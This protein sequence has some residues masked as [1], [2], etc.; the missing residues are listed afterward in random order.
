MTEEAN[1]QQPVFPPEIFEII[2]NNLAARPW[3]IVLTAEQGAALRSC[4]L[5]CKMFLPLARAHLLYRLAQL[6]FDDQDLDHLNQG[7]SRHLPVNQF[8]DLWERKPFIKRYVQQLSLQLKN[9]TW[10]SIPEAEL[11]RNTNSLLSLPSVKSI[12]ISY[13]QAAGLV[14]KLSSSDQIGAMCIRLIDTYAAKKT[15]HTLIAKKMA[16]LPFQQLFA[17]G[18]LTTLS[19]DRCCMPPLTGPIIGIKSLTLRKM[20]LPVSTLSFFP[21]LEDLCIIRANIT[22]C[23]NPANFSPPSFR[24]K[25]LVLDQCAENVYT[26]L[27][28]FATSIS[29]FFQYFYDKAEKQSVKPFSH[30]TK[31][32]VVLAN[33]SQ[34]SVM[35]PILKDVAQTLR[36]FSFGGS[37]TGIEVYVLTDDS[38]QFIAQEEDV[39]EALALKIA[40]GTGAMAATC[41]EGLNVATQGGPNTAMTM[42]NDDSEYISQQPVFPLEIFEVI[43]DI[44]AARPSTIALTKEQ[45]TTLKA[46]ALVCKMFLNLARPHLYRFVEVTLETVTVRLPELRHLNDFVHLW[47]RKPVIKQYVQQLSFQLQNLNWPALPSEAE[48]ERYA[49]SLSSLPSVKIIAI[50]YRQCRRASNAAQIPADIAKLSTSDRVGALF[51]RL[52]E[53]CAA[54]KTL[55]TLSC[56]KM[57]QLPYQQLFASVTLTTLSLDR[58]GVPPLTEP[59]RGLKSLTLRKMPLPVS[60]LSFF[61]DLDYLG[62]FRADITKC[63]RAAS[64]P[65]P[66]FGLK[67][68]D[69]DRCT[70]FNESGSLIA[71]VSTFLQFYYD[72]AEEQGVK[73][74]SHLTTLA[75]IV[76]QDD[77]SEL[78]VFE[79]LLKDISGT[80]QSFTFG[81]FPP[82]QILTLDFIKHLHTETTTVSLRYQSMQWLDL[83]DDVN[84]S[85]V[86][87][88]PLITSCYPSFPLDRILERFMTQNTSSQSSDSD[89][90]DDHPLETGLKCWIQYFA[91]LPSSLMGFTDIDKVDVYMVVND[92]GHN[93][94]IKDEGDMSDTFAQR[95]AA[96]SGGMVATRLDGLNSAQ[97]SRAQIMFYLA[98]DE[99]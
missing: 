67:T 33:Y 99:N 23:D 36:W 51:M 10:P 71:S 61:P 5:T 98:C 80:L 76:I 60:T 81:A 93:V 53:A 50:S 97:G 72:K 73:P 74:F 88:V 49:H 13:S 8:V 82:P 11:D 37:I 83:S 3:T 21:D 7:A 17:S 27:D 48:F 24:L 19:L 84:I 41:V 39:T 44:L 85:F 46:C 43:I 6:Q 18:S 63:D 87:L 35:E 90:S 40:N 42:T 30:L 38:R 78:S 94:F 86:T 26:N 9:Y 58:C 55:H 32:F 68:L 20:P 28:A 91:T 12:A 45:T 14:P 54:R 95:I 64:L 52:I 47:E 34:F 89:S 79:P 77:Y 22:N 66:S 31:L 25:S 62:I 16:E 56:K 69:L 29:T 96:S 75:A 15:L 4:S 70:Y 2:I 92:A 59:I 1:S 65:P 57:A